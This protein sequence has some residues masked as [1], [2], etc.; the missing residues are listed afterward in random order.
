MASA[1]FICEAAASKSHFFPARTVLPVFFQRGK[2]TTGLPDGK[3]MRSSN[4]Q[5]GAR[6]HR[7]NV[8]EGKEFKKVFFKKEPDF[9]SPG[10]TRSRKCSRVAL[11]HTTTTTRLHDRLHARRPGCLSGASTAGRRPKENSGDLPTAPS[12]RP[13]PEALR[14]FTPCVSDCDSSSCGAMPARRVASPPP[15]L[16]LGCTRAEGGGGEGG[17]RAPAPLC[18][19]SLG[20]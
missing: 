20:F 10:V 4:L 12:V 5:H 8:A 16:I 11:R 2:V 15:L 6:R 3:H 7:G 9:F 18:K 13:P 14:H 17:A 19:T 1:G